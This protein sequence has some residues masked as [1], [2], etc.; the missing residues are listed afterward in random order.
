[1]H[2]N[3]AFMAA[4]HV[5]KPTA[6]TWVFDDAGFEAFTNELILK[7]CNIVQARQ[8]GNNPYDCLTVLEI[9]EYFGIEAN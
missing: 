2:D 6:D 1:M 9:K 3:I 8:G 4:E 5:C 7:C